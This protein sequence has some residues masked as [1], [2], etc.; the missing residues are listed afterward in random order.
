MKEEKEE[1]VN[2]N[3]NSKY[4]FYDEKKETI[5][6]GDEEVR[7]LSYYYLDTQYLIKEDETSA[8]YY[9]LRRQLYADNILVADNIVGVD[10]EKKNLEDIVKGKMYESFDTFDDMSTNDGYVVIE[11]ISKDFFIYDNNKLRDIED[12]ATTTYV[13]NDEGKV[14]KTIVSR[15][16]FYGLVGIAVDSSNVGDRHSIIPEPIDD[17]DAS[18]LA[19]K[20]YIYPDNMFVDVH[21]NFI[22]YIVGDC[23][24]IS[25]YKMSIDDGSIKDELVTT[26]YESQI[27]SVGGC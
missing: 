27:I 21:D 13:L 23:D 26:Y 7:L 2:P 15:R 4:T 5:K 9:I 8:K 6:L 3:K 22:Y 25:E 24:D 12:C 14:L 16:P 20:R 19:G 18:D 11:L 1:L 10:Q 17:Y